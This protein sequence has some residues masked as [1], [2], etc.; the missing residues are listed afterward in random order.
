MSVE[1]DATAGSHA[2]RLIRMVPGADR[3]IAIHDPEIIYLIEPALLEKLRPFATPATLTAGQ[4]PTVN[5]RVAK[6]GR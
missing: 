2:I 6:V 5:L 3:I 1:T 4:T